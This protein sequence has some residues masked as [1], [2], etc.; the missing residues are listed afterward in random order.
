M[1]RKIPWDLRISE[2]KHNEIMRDLPPIRREPSW[3]LRLHVAGVALFLAVCIGL[4]LIPAHGT[5]L[6]IPKKPRGIV[7]NLTMHREKGP[8]P[9]Y[10]P[11]DKVRKVVVPIDRPAGMP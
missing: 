1:R 4:A 9:K 11:E 6:P 5:E 8:A 7:I 2:Q 10:V 3:H